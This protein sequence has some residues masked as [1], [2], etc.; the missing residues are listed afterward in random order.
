MNTVKGKHVALLLKQPRML[1]FAEVPTPHPSGEEVLLKVLSVGIC[2]SDVLRWKG[3]MPCPEEWRAGAGTHEVVGAVAA[4][5]E[6]VPNSLRMGQRV[7]VYPLGL[8]TEDDEYTR[9]GLTHH[10]KKVLRVGGMQEYVLLPHYRCLVSL[11]GLDDFHAAAPLGCAALTAY[12]AVKKVKYHVESDDYVAVIGLGGL[13]LYAV[14]FIKALMPYVNLIGID[15]RDNVLDF[16]SKMAKMDVLVN[17]AKEDPL[18]VIGNATKG[19]GVKALVDFVGGTKTVG[20]Y[21]KA[22][23][24][25]G[26]YVIVG[27]MDDE[28]MLSDM[29]NLI[30][31]EVM[32]HGSFMGSMHDQYEVVDLAKRKIVNHSSVVTRRLKFDAQE[33]NNAFRDLDEGKIIGRQIVVLG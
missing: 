19:R 10:A 9:R 11:E 12:G 25:L 33:V 32:I 15:I 5:G 3:E 28:V 22:I 21:V 17:A 29:R 23:S 30:A 14:Q 4:C 8:Y 26:I 20:T 24:H 7:L 16:A 2:H 6:R 31:K 1:A 13:G 18:K 27:I